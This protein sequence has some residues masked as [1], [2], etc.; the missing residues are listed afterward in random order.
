VKTWSEV[1]ALAKLPGVTDLGQGWPD[2]PSSSVARAEAARILTDVSPATVKLN[3]YAPIG[4]SARLKKSIVDFSKRQYGVDLDADKNVLV[5]TSGTEALFNA[6]QALCDPGDEVVL[7]EP[8]FPWYLPCVRL[9]G[10]IPKVVTLEAPSFKIEPDSLRAAFSEKTKLIVFN[11]PHNPT[12][13]C[14]TQ[15]ELEMIATLCLEFDALALYDEVYETSVYGGGKH[16]RLPAVEGMA[17]RTLTVSSAGKVFNLTGWRIGWMTGPEDLIAGC[18]AMCGYTTFSAATPLQEGIASALAEEPQAF[19]A[20][21][22]AQFEKNFTM[23]AEALTAM[24]LQVC[25]A[26]GTVG[27]YFLVADVA[28]TG[29]TALEFC[30]WLASEKK[31]AAVPLG[32]FYEPRPEGSDW[33]C[34]LVRFAICK[35]GA[36]IEEACK[37]LAA[38]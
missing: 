19:Y 11:S 17:E 33:S 18:R 28:S 24:G 38:K 35:Q 29:K 27:G 34:S 13:H 10:G 3:Q 12:G 37:K 22:T 2:I 7:F 25:C 20:G 4:G 8:F 31:V 15:E 26:D 5:T 9:A 23:L 14:A 1:I 32:V 30:K 6:V 36:T 21:V 16:L